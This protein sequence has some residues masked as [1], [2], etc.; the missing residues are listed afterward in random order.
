MNVVLVGMMG[1]GKTTVG[2]I[3]AR[4]LGWPLVDTDQVVV[5]RAGRSIP[6]LFA[7]EGEKGFRAREA[8][9]IAWAAA[10]DNLVIATGGGAVLAPANRE[11]LR[12]S[13]VVFWLD[14]PPE[15]LYRR[16]A[17]QGVQGRPL[18]A[19]AE[20]GDPLAAVAKLA[21]SRAQ[22]YREA[23]HCRIDTTGRS[24]EEVAK[25]IRERLLSGEYHSAV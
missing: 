13:G 10:Q 11:A 9:A 16:A 3:L 5:E 20:S 18:L 17:A 2:R 1:A 23:A 19:G 15:E 22:A 25:E 21:E 24:P 14:A 6:E 12:R 4:E 8:E 7:T